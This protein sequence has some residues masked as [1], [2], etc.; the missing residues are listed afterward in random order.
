MTWRVI[1]SLLLKSSFASRYRRDSEESAAT[2][3]DIFVAR[4]GAWGWEGSGSGFSWTRARAMLQ[5]LAP[6]SRTFGN[7]R[8]ISWKLVSYMH[9]RQLL[10]LST[11]Q[12]SFRHSHGDLIL[13]I[14]GLTA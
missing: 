8:L 5:E 14:V 12:Q 4:G 7:C 6:R 1:L 9:C 11:Y 3:S 13:Q 10:G 2:S